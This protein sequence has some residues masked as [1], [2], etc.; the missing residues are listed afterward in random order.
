MNIIAT[1]IKVS[2]RIQASNGN[3]I[4]VIGVCCFVLGACKKKMEKKYLKAK[5]RY[6]EALKMKP[7]FYQ[8]LVALWQQKFEYAKFL[9][10]TIDSN[11]DLAMWSS[12]E[13]L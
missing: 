9:G 5:H 2:H 1:H 11:V 6:K 13:V 10:I 8:G 12:E 4:N 7:D 3:D